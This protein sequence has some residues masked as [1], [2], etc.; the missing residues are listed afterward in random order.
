MGPTFWEWCKI[1]VL[2][3]VIVGYLSFLG[4]WA[5]A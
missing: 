4:A 2:M 1:V 3:A 5:G